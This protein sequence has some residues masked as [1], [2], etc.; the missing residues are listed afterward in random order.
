[1]AIGEAGVEGVLRGGAGAACD[2]EVALDFA[3][4]EPGVAVTFEGADDP[5]VAEGEGDEGGVGEVLEGL[6]DRVHGGRYAGRT[7]LQ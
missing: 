7:G 4:G 5:V 3:G 6:E 1:M 2:A